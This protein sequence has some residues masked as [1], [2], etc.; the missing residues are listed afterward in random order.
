MD[1]ALYVVTRDGHNGDV[2]D[3]NATTWA[4]WL[5]QRA[6]TIKAGGW[7]VESADAQQ[8][9]T[10]EHLYLWLE[11]RHSLL[12]RQYIRDDTTDVDED[13]EVEGSAP[14]HSVAHPM[15]KYGAIV[16][17]D[18]YEQLEAVRNQHDPHLYA[19]AA[20]FREAGFMEARV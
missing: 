7:T 4:I 2:Y 18:F 17:D 10:F 19:C 15:L 12:Q 8:R 9:L 20:N 14:S 5:V 1:S 16:A 6:H 11:G 13:P 3:V